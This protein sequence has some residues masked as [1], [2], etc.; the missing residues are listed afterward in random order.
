MEEP[1]VK[2]EVCV[3][4]IASAITAQ[5]CGAWR[6]EFCDNMS[7]GGTTPSIGQIAELRNALNIKLN[8]II[9]PR[10]GDF[11]YSK[12]EFSA[13]C[14]DIKMCGENK[15]DGVVIGMLTPD[16]SVDMVRCNV[17]A[18]IA[19]TYKMSVT[20]HRA[21]DVCNNQEEALEDIITLGCDRLLTSG[22]EATAEEGVETLKK[23]IEQA[24]G[25]IIIMP[26][27]G[28][29][30]GNAANIIIRTG[31][32]EIHGTFRSKYESHLK[33]PA[34]ADYS[35]YF[36]DPDKVKAVVNATKSLKL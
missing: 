23:L 13:M 19:R 30:P 17:L 29:T 3:D 5:L 25:R 10:G 21:F 14:K 16:G 31:C 7:E 9:R 18:E 11:V 32:K 1:Q 33:H 20:F 8:V 28:V 15:C 12:E 6:V 4:S 22:G 36:T 26:G 24:A 27:S 2:V 34:W 35:C